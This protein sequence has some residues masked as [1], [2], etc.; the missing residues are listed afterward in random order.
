MANTPSDDLK[1]TAERLEEIQK[2]MLEQT[3]LQ[4]N[5]TM[6]GGVSLDSDSARELRQL[7]DQAVAEMMKQANIGSGI[8]GRPPNLN[9]LAGELEK[10]AQESSGIVD[11]NIDLTEK[12]VSPHITT[13]AHGLPELNYGKAGAC[14]LRF[15]L[16][17]IARLRVEVYE[18]FHNI[19]G[20]LENRMTDT[21]PKN[22]D[23]GELHPWFSF[24]RNG[25]GNAVR[26]QVNQLSEILV[27]FCSGDCVFHKPIWFDDN[28]PDVGAGYQ[29]IIVSHEAV[30]GV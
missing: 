1:S 26:V 23:W 30:L 21:W 6:P 16:P 10:M 24:G 20:I 7:Q 19:N 4:N 2:Q 9:E 14:E 11:G 29:P 25:A 13:A 12:K 15:D 27:V 28:G 18:P 8:S 22:G 17:A 5:P 3:S